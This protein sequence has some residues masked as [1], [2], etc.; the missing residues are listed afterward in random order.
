MRN[1]RIE[2]ELDLE[3]ER[4]IRKNRKQTKA[5]K[6][7]F[8]A[9][10]RKAT[11]EQA[12]TSQLARV[13]EEQPTLEQEQV[14]LTQEAN[15][16]NRPPQRG[17]NLEDLT[18]PH[19]DG[20]GSCINPLTIAANSFEI[21]P[22]LTQLVRGDQFGGRKEEDPNLHIY[23]FLQICGTIKING[24]TDAAI[25]LRLFPF[26]LKDEA[27][28]WLQSQPTG[29]ITTWED[30]VSKFLAQFFPLSKYDQY[31]AEISCFKQ[32]DGESFATAWKKFKALL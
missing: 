23:K 13:V 15:M 20:C 17:M 12:T 30:L 32:R 24:V 1:K 3:L 25:R 7:K 9:H 2:F 14:V 19:L 27:L 6:D 31:R 21:K 16:E 4:T 8:K 29:S 22:A 5:N 11:Q 26:S 28:D 10:R 18:A